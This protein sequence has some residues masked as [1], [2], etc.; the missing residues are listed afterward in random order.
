VGLLPSELRDRFGVQWT[1]ARQTRFQALGA[2]ARAADPLMPAVNR[3]Y[4]PENVLR[5]R[6][7]SIEREYLAGAGAP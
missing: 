3:I 2:I 7:A 4:S 6:R 1:R 5:W